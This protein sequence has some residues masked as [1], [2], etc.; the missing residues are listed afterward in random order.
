[1]VQTTNEIDILDDAYRWCK[2][3]QK[4][5]KGN[6]NPRSYYKCTNVGCPMR[7]HVDSRHREFHHGHKKQDVSCKQQDAQMRKK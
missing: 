6:P 7:K 4:M 1:V 3:G 5:T 2:Y